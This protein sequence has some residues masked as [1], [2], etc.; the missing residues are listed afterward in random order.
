MVS[1]LRDAV[2]HADV[3]EEE[4]DEDNDE[5]ASSLSGL[6]RLDAPSSSVRPSARLAIERKEQ[7]IF[8]FHCRQKQ[9]KVVTVSPFESLPLT[10]SGS[11]I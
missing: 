1:L 9:L 11:S 6:W 10:A 2:S 4:D 7:K 3:T 8:D 5:G